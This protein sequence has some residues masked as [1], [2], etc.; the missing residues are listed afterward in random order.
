[1][2]NGTQSWALAQC[3]PKQNNIAALTNMLGKGTAAA[4]NFA[5]L[6]K[7]KK[8]SP[9]CKTYPN[10]PSWARPASQENAYGGA[11][12]PPFPNPTWVP[13]WARRGGAGRGG[14]GRL[15]GASRA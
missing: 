9:N 3:A 12:F 10:P 13:G 6:F 11:D 14:A 7:C 15:A 1:M 5:N 4:A 2:L 8:G